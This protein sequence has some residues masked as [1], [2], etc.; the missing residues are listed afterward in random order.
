[1]K[2]LDVVKEDMQEVGASEDEVFDRSLRRICCDVP[3]WEKP[4][5]IIILF[6][7]LPH[8][9]SDLLSMSLSFSLV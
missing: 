1:M 3:W 2:C 5:N 4:T 9:L 8:V 6:I 7:S